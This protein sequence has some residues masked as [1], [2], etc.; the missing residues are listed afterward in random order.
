MKRII[1]ILMSLAML[2]GCVSS[3]TYLRNGRYDDAIKKAAHKLK[4]NPDKIK[5]IPIL[6][7]AYSLANNQDIERIAFLKKSGQPDI[8]DEVFDRYNQL[9]MRQDI[10]KTLPPEV[11]SKINFTPAN[12]DNDILESK[13]KAAEYFYVHA[14]T[15]L[16]KNDRMLARQAYDELLKVKGYYPNY[17]DVDNQIDKAFIM[18]TT[19]VLFKMNNLAPVGLPSGFEDELLKIAIKDLNT[20]WINFDSREVN[21]QNYDY[22]ILLNIKGIDVSPERIH[23]NTWVE[24]REVEDGWQYQYDAHG[25]VM[26]DT[27]GNDIKIKKYKTISCQILETQMN[28]TSVVS[29]VIDFYDNQTNQLLKSEPINANADFN[30]NFLQAHGDFDALKTETRNRLGRPMPFPNDLEMIMMADNIL[31]D[32]AKNIIISNKF[33]FK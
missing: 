24:S 13:R 21:G 31:K 12:Y 30:Y 16:D 22:V 17:K 15:L 28:K 33:L 27:A 11:L 6:E 10:V 9:K 5:E 23:E 29:G 4:I 19:N 26:K 20:K 2:G 1:I 18:G 14:L 8:W 7:Q 25:N 32:V 3:K